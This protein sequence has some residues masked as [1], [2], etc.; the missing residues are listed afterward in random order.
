M[1]I[2]KE[3][4]EAN[5]FNYTK[6]IKLIKE[7]IYIKFQFDIYFN[8]YDYDNIYIIYSGEILPKNIYINKEK[9]YAINK[10]FIQFIINDNNNLD[11]IVLTLSDFIMFKVVG[12]WIQFTKKR[13]RHRIGLKLLGVVSPHLG[14]PVFMDFNV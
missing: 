7:L 9:V 14:N 8:I 5:K 4:F 6:P 11:I 13:K 12:H 1:L 2:T 3:Y 10:F